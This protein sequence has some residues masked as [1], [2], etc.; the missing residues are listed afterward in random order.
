MYDKFVG[1]AA[2]AVHFGQLALWLMLG[3]PRV[4]NV[5]PNTSKHWQ[6]TAHPDS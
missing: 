1:T 3:I 5:T 2:D 6:P 4:P